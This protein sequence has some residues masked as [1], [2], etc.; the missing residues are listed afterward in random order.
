VTELSPEDKFAAELDAAQQRIVNH[1]GYKEKQLCDGL[2]RTVY[3]VFMPN[4]NDLLALFDRAAS[5]ANLAVELFQNVRRP[6]VRTR[7]EGAV[8]RAL[9]N[10]V[11]SA[12]ALVE[13][14][15]RIMRGRSGPIIDELERRKRDVIAHPE[16]PFVHNL[17]N[18]VLHHSLP[19]IGH[20]VRLQ[21]QPGVLAT[22]EIQL[23]VRQLTAWDGW[24][25]AAR[26]FVESQ[27]EVLMLRPVIAIHAELTVQLNL[28]LYEQL[29]AANEPALSEVNRLV[30]ERNAILGGTDLQEARRVTEEWTK[31]RE[32]S[33]PDPNFDIRT[34]MPRQKLSSP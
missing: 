21:P 2:A 9:H 7:F 27:G 8:M 13:H 14:T 32:R 12:T 5:D 1:A 25:A 3:A 26:R 16:V 33:R 30:V 11:A 22:S 24:S 4:R 17:R 34:L 23:R 28:W 15:R 29:A 6:V 20:E 31:R 19:F 10:Y 18:Y